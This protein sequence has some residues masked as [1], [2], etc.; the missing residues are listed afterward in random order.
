MNILDSFNRANGGVGSNWSGT[1]DTGAYKI[2]SNRLDVQAGGPI[3]WKTPFGTNQEAF[4][5][6]S[7][8]DTRSR[9]QGVLLKVQTGSLLQA[10]AI[11]VVYDAVARAVRVET[12]RVNTLTWTLYASQAMPFSNGDRLGARLGCSRATSSG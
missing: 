2:D 4:V 9:E 8:I 10:G 12:L 3:Y 7:M 11:A 6:L 5:T 1:T